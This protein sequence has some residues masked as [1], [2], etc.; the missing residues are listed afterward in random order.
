MGNGLLMQS[1]PRL[2]RSGWRSGARRDEEAAAKLASLI[3][4]T[5]YYREG[6]S[7]EE[8]GIAGLSKDEIEKVLQEGF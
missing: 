8:P 1:T 5:D 6:R 2:R 3:N 4:Q 7:L